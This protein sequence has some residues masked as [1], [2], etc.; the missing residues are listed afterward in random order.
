M[1]TSGA[2]TDST[3][4][5]ADRSAPAIWSGPIRRSGTPSATRTAA[6]TVTPVAIARMSSIG[7]IVP[8]RMRAATTTSTVSQAALRHGRLSQGEAATTK[9]TAP[10]IT[11]GPGNPALAIHESRARLSARTSGC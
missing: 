5:P 2:Q 4:R 9:A 3:G 6:P 8:V 1:S 10:A 11:E 7:K